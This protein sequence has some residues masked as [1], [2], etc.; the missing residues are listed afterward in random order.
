MSTAKVVYRKNNEHFPIFIDPCKVIIDE[1]KVDIVQLEK[2][3][4]NFFNFK[5][6]ELTLGEK[7]NNIELFKGLVRHYSNH[8]LERELF[9]EL[10]E[11]Y[12]G[13]N[14]FPSSLYYESIS[15]MQKNIL[16]MYQLSYCHYVLG[17]TNKMKGNF[18]RYCCGISSRNLLTSF[19]EAGILSAIQVYDSRDD[20]AYIIVPFILESHNHK[21]VV[22]VDPTSDQLVYDDKKKIRNNICIFTER[23]WTYSGDWRGGANLYPETVEISACSG[24]A[25]EDYDSYIDKALS[26]PVV[27]I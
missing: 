27:V 19:W 20:H 4:D 10:S 22:L 9:G 17:K 25:T 12:F 7:I 1:V 11:S 26:S 5:L 18:P 15:E 8:Y 24:Y 2:S 3:M 6:S 13:G 21:G 16:L 23:N 14:L